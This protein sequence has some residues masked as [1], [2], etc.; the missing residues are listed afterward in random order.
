MVFDFITD[1]LTFKFFQIQVLKIVGT[2]VR[3]YAR[4]TLAAAKLKG[5]FRL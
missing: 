4:S 3:N 2:F 1:N 5:K